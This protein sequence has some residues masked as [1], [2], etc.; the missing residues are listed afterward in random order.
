MNPW[1][2]VMT[3]KEAAAYLRVSVTTLNQL[4]NREFLPVRRLGR[5]RRYFKSDLD[6]WSAARMSG[7][8]G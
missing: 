5:N 4:E 1:P 2:D 6:K 7:V 8:A 3:Y